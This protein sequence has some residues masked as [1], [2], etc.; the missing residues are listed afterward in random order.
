[1]RR[2]RKINTILTPTLSLKER[3]KRS[4]RE[5]RNAANATPRSGDNYKTESEA[6]NPAFI[7]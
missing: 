6:P 4:P 1:M 5:E 2:D 3:E 7:K